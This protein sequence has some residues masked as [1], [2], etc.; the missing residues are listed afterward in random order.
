FPYT[1]LFRS[2]DCIIPLRRRGFERFLLCLACRYCGRYLLFHLCCHSNC[3]GSDAK[4]NCQRKCGRS[5]KENCLIIYKTLR[6]ST[7]RWGGAFFLSN[8]AHKQRNTANWVLNHG[9]SLITLQ[10]I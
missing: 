6:K 9:F 2:C 5:S 8:F 10:S 7:A 1:T 3:S 4:R